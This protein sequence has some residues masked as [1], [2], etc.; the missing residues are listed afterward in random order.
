[1]SSL[2]PGYEYDIFISYRQKDN[3]YDGWITAFVDNLKKELEA[4]FKEDISVYLDINPLDG[5]LETHDID[6]SLKAKLKCLIFIPIISRTYCDPKS[7]AWEYEFKA[8]IEQASEDHFGLKVKLPDGNVSSRVLPV[9]IHELDYEDIKLCESVLGGALRGVEFIYKEPGVNK[10]LTAED[11]EKRNLNNTKYRIQINK[12]ALAIKEIISGLN[13]DFVAHI[14]ENT[15]SAEAL[16]EIKKKMGGKE[17]E[18]QTKFGLIRYKYLSGIVI[19]ALLIFAAIFLYPKIF[20]ADKLANVRTSDGRIIVAVMPFRNLTNDTTWNVWQ[21]GIQDNLISALSNSRELKVRQTGSITPLIESKGLLNYAS[22][23]PDVASKISQELDANV[24]I[25]G[26]INEAGSTIRINAQLIDSK[27]EEAFRSFQIEGTAGN[28]LHII[29][30]LSWMLNNFLAV[31][32]MEKELTPSY[33]IFSSTNSPEAYRYFIYGQKA[34]LKK[35]FSTAIKM[36]SQSIAVDS[37]FTYPAI[38]LPFAYRNQ[39]LYDQAIK[40]SLQIYE[41]RDQMPIQQK[42]FTNYIHAIF[43]E[44]TYEAIKYL[45]Q[46][47]ELDDQVPTFHDALVINYNRL[48]QYDKSIPEGE[49]SL[50]IYKKWGLIPE[51]VWTYT[52]LGLAYHYTGQYDKEKAL[53]NKAERDFPDNTDLSYRQ[54]IL[55]LAEGDTIKA[56]RYMDKYISGCRDN[57][58]SEA[59]IKIRLSNIYSEAGI[60]DK[61]EE[62][63]RQALSLEPENT[64]MLYSLAY[65]LIDGRRNI[66]EGLELISKALEKQPDNYLFLD[67]KGLG[68][69][70]KGKYKEAVEILEKAWSL[71]PYYNHEI[72]LHLEDAKN[73]VSRQMN[74]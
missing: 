22:I 38:M 7:F 33:K 9:R 20:K 58:S 42:I 59:S 57:S 28:I 63:C 31:S 56:N 10:P 36:Y 5:L 43:F 32:K 39:H 64:A 71:K 74:D 29:D 12:V 54:A 40:W 26:S 48:N 69:F 41:K 14:K 18:T 24:F 21:D 34:F 2:I 16:E 8:F 1:M 50:N 73:A 17:K 27:T 60:P 47:L 44:T 30:S 53:Y 37:N 72:Y 62:Y 11:D 68:L 3:K 23:T 67:T 49:K 61:A 66:N 55:L 51:S 46:L 25:Y 13:R 35:D 15:K 19:L 70:K 4:T 52:N 65:L 6:A 45:N